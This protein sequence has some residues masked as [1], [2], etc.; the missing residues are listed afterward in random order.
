MKKKKTL[1]ECSHAR[2]KGER[3]T[4]C[5]GHPFSLKSE[6]GGIEVKR[7]AKGEPLAL[8]ICQACGDFERIGSFISEE[9]RGW[10]KK[11]EASGNRA[12]NRET[13]RE[14]VASGRSS[15]EIEGQ[16]CKIS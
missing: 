16:L 6:D 9:A 5:N 15:I 12:N 2:V 13:L 8:N 4:C 11:Q 7:L 3:I 14:A 1:Y 10:L